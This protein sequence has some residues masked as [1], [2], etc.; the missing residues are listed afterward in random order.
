MRLGTDTRQHD[1]CITQSQQREWSQAGDKVPL[2]VA[3]LWGQ[4]GACWYMLRRCADGQKD[5][6]HFTD[7]LDR[8]HCH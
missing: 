4:Q 6:C 5:L 1:V 7:R 2:G 8:T 3:W